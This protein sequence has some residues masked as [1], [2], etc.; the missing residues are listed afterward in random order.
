MKRL[1]L[2]LLVLLVACVFSGP[3]QA[4]EGDEFTTNSWAINSSGNLLPSSSNA[5]GVGSSSRYPSKTYGGQ[6]IQKT[7]STLGTNVSAPDVSGSNVFITSA[8]S[9]YIAIPDLLNAEA[10]QIVILIGGSSTNPTFV[11][12]SGNFNLSAEMSLNTDDVLILLVRADND[13]VEIGRVNN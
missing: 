2:C 12:D 4:T 7:I 11:A 13:Y 6:L 5:Y 3:A 10:G 1:M 8:N 9:Q